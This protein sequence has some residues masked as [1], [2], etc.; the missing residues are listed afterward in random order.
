MD[1][2]G[3]VKEVAPGVPVILLSGTVGEDLA[4]D[5]IKMGI[6]DY[7]LKDQRARLP[8]AL[9]RAKEERALRD[10][11]TNAVKA[12]RESEERYRTLVE[13]AP[14]AIVVLDVE[15]GMFVDCN[16]N[17]LRLF[18]ITRAELLTRG[19]ADFGPALQ[20]DGRSS[21]REFGEHI[22]AALAGGRLCFEW[23]YSNPC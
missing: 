10:A 15:S 13:N 9:R 5:C 18:R 14:E 2:L 16:D 3:I 20:P 7:V 8:M 12:L 11:E 4:V 22:A 1:A 21:T 6:T 17:A 23:M 19:N